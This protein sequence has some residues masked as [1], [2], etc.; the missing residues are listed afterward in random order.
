MGSPKAETT[1]P[2]NIHPQFASK[3]QNNPPNMSQNLISGISKFEKMFSDEITSYTSITSETLSQNFLFFIFFANL[4]P[5]T[6][7]QYFGRS[8][9]SN[10]CW[11]LPNYPDR[12]L[13]PSFRRPKV[14]VALSL[15]PT[16][17]TTTS[18]SSSSLMVFDLRLGNLHQSFSPSS[19]VTVTICSNG[20][21]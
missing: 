17:T 21:S 10:L 11:P 8:P 1:L 13:I 3:L 20:L 2:A 18:L 7:I 14:F 16:V 5:A 19:P 12:H 9:Q 15:E 6:Q 4:N